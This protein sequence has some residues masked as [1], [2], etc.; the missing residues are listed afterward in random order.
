MYIDPKNEEIQILL[1]KALNLIEEI[2]LENCFVPKAKQICIT[3][4]GFI[5]K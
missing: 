4:N 5:I 2:K 1:H 3:K